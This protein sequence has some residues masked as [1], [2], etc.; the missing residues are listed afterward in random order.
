MVT[1]MKDNISENDLKNHGFTDSEIDRLKEILT[2]PESKNDT[3]ATLLDDLRKRFWG[4]AICMFIVL[5]VTVF[6]ACNFESNDFT[7]PVIIIF[8]VFV[9]YK[10]TPVPMAYKAYKAH[11]KYK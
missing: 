4:S 3:Y 1:A 7:Y 8:L 11:L 10:L 2:R 9:I 5:I 6:W